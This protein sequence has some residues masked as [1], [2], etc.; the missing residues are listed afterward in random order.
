MELTMYQVRDA[1][2]QDASSAG[3]QLPCALSR[4]GFQTTSCC[5]S[6]RKQ[7]YLMFSRE[8]GEGFHLRWFTAVANAV[9]FRAW[10][11]AMARLIWQKS[12]RPAH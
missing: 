6:L 1:F 3:I 2:T 5:R 8:K 9:L 12:A 4:H 7:S 11:P 10:R